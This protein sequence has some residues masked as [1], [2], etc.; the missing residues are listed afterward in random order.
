MKVIL[1]KDVKAQGKKG[2]VINVSDGYANN[3]LFKN[4]LAIPASKENVNK[5]DKEKAVAAKLRAEEKAAAEELKAV[6]EKLELTFKVSVGANGK[7]FGSITNKEIEEDLSARGIV[8]DKKK[9]IV[10]S[11]IKS[12]GRFIV[13]CKLFPEVNAK[14]KIE[15]IEK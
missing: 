7:A 2:D 5:N 12:L 9:I 3:F 10:N 4:G 11:P 6:L 1:T 15:I 8:V 13:E 14:L